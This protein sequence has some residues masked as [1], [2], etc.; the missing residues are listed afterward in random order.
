MKKIL[1]LLIPFVTTAILLTANRSGELS[2]AEVD[3]PVREVTTMKADAVK[4][5]PTI[6]ATGKLASKEEIK[7]S[8]KTGGIIKNILVSE[9]QYVRKGQLLAELNLDEIGARTQQAQMQEQQAAINLDNA[10]LALNIAERDY[11]N[12]RGLFQD[13]V[14]TLEQLENAELQLNSARN[15]LEAAET[16]LRF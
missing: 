1:L 8:F 9:G 14:A 4:Y 12:A 15:Q 2:E 6:F 7:L 13:S 5:R 11:R 10:K 16:N 3:R